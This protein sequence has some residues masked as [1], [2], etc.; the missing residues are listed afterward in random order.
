M[1]VKKK[2]PLTKGGTAVSQKPLGGAS[3]EL[4]VRREGRNSRQRFHRNR[5]GVVV[6]RVSELAESTPRAFGLCSFVGSCF[7]ACCVMVDAGTD[8]RAYVATV[9]YSISVT[10][11]LTSA[12]EFLGFFPP[13]MISAGCP[14]AGIARSPV[15]LRLHCPEARTTIPGW[16]RHQRGAG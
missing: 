11:W 5:A 9:E 4:P 15:P 13:M 16:P 3:V 8:S 6:P 2:S 10:V 1:S 12:F 7:D 14:G